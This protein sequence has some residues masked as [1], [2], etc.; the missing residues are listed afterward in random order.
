MT[1]KWIE[2][3]AGLWSCR[4]SSSFLSLYVTTAS[5]GKFWPSVNGREVRRGYD[6]LK[7]A[8]QVAAEAAR[9]LCKEALQG[10][11]AE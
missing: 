11:E 10:L 8:Q 4:V 9:R 6:N 7:Q 5:D 2:I 3:T 1:G